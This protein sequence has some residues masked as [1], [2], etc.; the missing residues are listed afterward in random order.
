MYCGCMPGLRGGSIYQVVG[1]SWGRWTLLALAAW[2]VGSLLLIRWE[3]AFLVSA[4]F[5]AAVLV[6][7]LLDRVRAVFRGRRDAQR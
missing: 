2:L 4:L 1:A 6:A 3:P 7:A 5:A